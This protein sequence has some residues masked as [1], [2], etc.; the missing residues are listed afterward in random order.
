MTPGHGRK[1]QDSSRGQIES[2]LRSY[3][4]QTCGG[5]GKVNQDCLREFFCFVYGEFESSEF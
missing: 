3:F 5:Y 2:E 1:G 4:D